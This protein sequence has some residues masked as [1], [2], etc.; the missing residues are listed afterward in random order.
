MKRMSLA[1]LPTI[2]LILTITLVAFSKEPDMTLVGEINK[3][4]T[5]HV[6][7]NL[8]PGDFNITVFSNQEK[9]LMSCKYL[10]GAG[11]LGL[12]QKLTSRC[13]GNTKLSQKGFITV[14]ITNESSNTL[15]YNI[16]VHDNRK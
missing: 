9:A 11:N 1:I 7:V 8:A 15:N 12:E 5:K 2:F 6:K 4:E 13:L 3:Y 16:L 10:D 14:V